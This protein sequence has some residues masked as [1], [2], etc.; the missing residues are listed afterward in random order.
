MNIDHLNALPTTDLREALHRCC[1]AHQWVTLMAQA[2]P[3][4]DEEDLK[5][6]AAYYWEKM[7]EADILEAFTHHPRIGDIE[8]LRQRFASTRKWAGDEQAG[9]AEA[10]EATL[11]ALK[12]ANDAYFERFGFI[13]IVCATGKSAQEMLALLKARLPNDRDTELK[14]AAA[15]QLKITYLRLEKLP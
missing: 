5:T 6:K 3:F 9:S 7:G 13:F 12:S 10:D 15:E 1:G 8:G 4:L 14:V 2:K 11:Q